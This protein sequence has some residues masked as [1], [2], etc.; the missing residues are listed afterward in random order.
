MLGTA[1]ITFFA[2]RQYYIPKLKKVN[3]FNEEILRKTEEAQ[4]EYEQK[5]K[6]ID[7]AKSQLSFIYKDIESLSEQR[8]VTQ[9]QIATLKEAAKNASEAAYESYY[10]IG[11][12]NFETSM[13]NLFEHYAE[14]ENDYQKEYHQALAE[15]VESYQNQIADKQEELNDL[16]QVLENIKSKVNTAVEERKRQKEIEEQANFYKIILD[17]QDVSEIELLKKIQLRDNEPLNKIIWKYYYE[18]PATDMIGRVVGPRVIT[19]IYKL[20]NTIDGKCYVGQS[21]NIGER[22]KQHIKRALG[23]ETAT[24]NKLYPAMGEAGPENFTFEVLE[25][26]SKDELDAQEKYWQKFYQ[27]DTYGYSMK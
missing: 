9:N 11:Q 2:V 20:T 27:A 17:S 3:Y 7:E 21:T 14:A 16:I 24:R 13:N 18:K 19:G 4:F 10:A 8:I 23:A 1:I 6:D 22:F 25:S 5:L 26:C 12:Q 15:C